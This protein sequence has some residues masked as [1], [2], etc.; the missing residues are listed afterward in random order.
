V[1]YFATLIMDSML[2]RN[3]ADLPDCTALFP[4]PWEPHMLEQ[5]GGSKLMDLRPSVLLSRTI[6]DV[7]SMYIEIIKTAEHK[8]A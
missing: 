7:T 1:A 6:S 5:R 8:Y 3:V 2:L 4:P